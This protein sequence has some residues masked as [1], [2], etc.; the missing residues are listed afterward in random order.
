M[1]VYPEGTV[2]FLFTDIEGSTRLW[3][4]FPGAMKSALARHDAILRQAIEA[5]QGYLVK[6]TG[7]GMLVAF[8]T[9]AGALASGLAAQQT[10][11]AEPWVEIQPQA[12]RVRMAFHTGEVELRGGDY[13]GPALNRAAR[14]M[15]I[16][17]GGQL[18]LSDVTADLVRDDLPEGATLL[19]LGEHRLKDLARPEHVFQLTHPALPA[20]FPPLVTLE[21]FPNNLP[22]QLTSFIGREKELAETRQLMSASRLLTLIGPGGAGKTRLSIQLAAEVLPSLPDGAWLVEL[23]PLT[24]P[25]LVPQTVAAVIGVNEIPGLTLQQLLVNHLKRR[26]LLVVLDNCE[27]MVEA[28]ARLADMLLRACPELHLLASSREALGIAG[29]VIYRI[30]PM[31][32]PENAGTSPENLCRFESVQLFTERAAA[33]QPHFALTPQNAPAVAQ[34]CRRLD[35][36]PLAIELAAARVRLMSPE[37]IAAHLDDRFR[38]LTGGSRTALP[39]QQT[40]RSL[41]DWSYDL[42]P[43]SERLLFRRLAVFAGGWTFEA[44]EALSPDLDVFDGLA[45]LVNK[46]LVVED[47][48]QGWARFRFLETVRQY[49]RD[50]L[51]ESDEVSGIRNRHRDYYLHYIKAEQPHYMGSN[52]INWWD[53][54]DRE[55]DNLR[56]ALQWSLDTD[57]ESALRL[58]GALADYWERR[59]HFGE[60]RD[61]LIA[62][63]ERVAALPVV[64][65]PA[66]QARQLARA[67]ALLAFSQPNMGYQVNLDFIE[68]S[69][70]LYRSYGSRAELCLALGMAGFIKS[71][72]GDNLAAEP[73]LLE[74]VAVG[75]E[76]GDKFVLMF[77]LGVYSN[78]IL[79]ERGDLEA[80]RRVNDELLTSVRSMGRSW[81]YAQILMFLERYFWITGEPDRAREFCQE[82]VELFRQVGDRMMMTVLQSD[83]GHIMLAAGKLEEAAQI[84]R[85]TL[86][87]WREFDQRGAIAHQLESFAHLARCQGQFER[88]ACLYGAAEALRTATASL[89]MWYERRDYGREVAALR[90]QMPPQALDQ[91]WTSGC[92]LTI[93]Q[94]V[95]L[96][97]MEG[98]RWII[99]PMA[100]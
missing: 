67:R 51:F 24:D 86:P 62:S 55:Q 25:V 29:E 87:V 11:F 60:A 37:Q 23:A 100:R 16:G 75:R 97:L 12:I 83:L 98:E 18:L 79:V 85:Q 47:E 42:L 92:S 28:C 19:D 15:S 26:R 96:A 76:S 17:H 94:A 65:G 3:E 66:W 38:L 36:I 30:P 84:Y 7:D 22:A 89:M 50:R 88:A 91:A 9:A 80:A 63:L 56:A 34:I 10:L 39:R 41:I 1:A 99:D 70:R 5:H 93:E 43:D 69:I 45:Q 35:G 78:Q 31:A 27:H 64:E 77:A 82:A 20:D 2:T 61:W 58:A 21:S 49:A 95:D 40:L 14:L 71:M 53:D 73:D 33:A 6:S 48:L 52:P 13:F 8:Q 57:P 74:S 68:E 54:C 44:A 72:R 59:G 90:Q 4:Q 46:S 32:L 81:S